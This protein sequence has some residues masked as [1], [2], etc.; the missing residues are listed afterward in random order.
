MIDLFV[1]A[2]LVVQTL[3][4]SPIERQSVAADDENQLFLS[5]R[6]SRRFAVAELFPTASPPLVSHLVVAVEDCCGIVGSVYVFGD[7]VND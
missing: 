6:C 3:Q 5:P 7:L 4:P 2:L 1:P